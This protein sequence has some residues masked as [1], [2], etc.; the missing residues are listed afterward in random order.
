MIRR[1]LFLFIIISN[2]LFSQ[3]KDKDMTYSIFPNPANEFI[4]LKI[5]NNSI[6]DYNFS[7]HSLIGNQMDFQQEKISDNEMRF[8]I[9]SF[10]SGYYFILIDFKNENRNNAIKRIAK[11]EVGYLINPDNSSS[12]GIYDHFYSD[13]I[14]EN[15]KIS[16]HYIVEAILFLIEDDEIKS[17]EF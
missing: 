10:N 16:T 15:T 12:I 13:S 8:V 3:E 11:E 9:N 7:I 4:N 14:W 5:D 2:P 17:I 6:D 1:I